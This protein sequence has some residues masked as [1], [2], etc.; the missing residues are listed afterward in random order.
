[1]QGSVDDDYISKM[2]RPKLKIA[3]NHWLRD[4]S[5]TKS[6]VSAAVN[7]RELPLP[8]YNVNKNLKN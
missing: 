4:Y 5:E 3:S 2:T 8:A 7:W 1:V 6:V